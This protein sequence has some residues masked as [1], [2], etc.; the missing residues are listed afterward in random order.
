M[1]SLTIQI[2]DDVAKGLM[3]EAAQRNISLEQV[4]AEQLARLSPATRS[5]AP[6]VSYASLFGAARGPGT[7]TSREEVDLYLA[8]LRAEW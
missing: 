5:E 1:T 7:H 2:P 6:R 8:E 4:A 3:A